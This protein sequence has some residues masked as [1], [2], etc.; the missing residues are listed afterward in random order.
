MSR[1]VRTLCIDAGIKHSHSNSLRPVK[2]SDF[3]RFEVVAR[4]QLPLAR[5]I[6]IRI[7]V[8]EFDFQ[9]IA[10]HLRQM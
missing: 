8:T 1:K 4:R 6:K 9:A 2:G 3:G 10:S 5:R 7:G